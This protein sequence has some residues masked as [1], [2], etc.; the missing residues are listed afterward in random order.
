MYKR[1][2]VPLD[3]SRLAEGILPLVLLITGP[4]DLEV[5]LVRVVPPIP[6]QTLEGTGPFMVDVVATRL[7]EARE[8]LAGVAANLRKRGVRVITEARTG[9]PVTELV[10]AAREPGADLIAMTT[11]GRSG[12]GRLLF[13]SVA[14]AVLRQAKVP[15]LMMRLTER[16]ASTAEAA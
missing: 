12:F 1:V 8:Y 14:E 9:E 3:G 13:G 7:E 15:V 2:L 5:V 11:H 6:P 16:Q 4:L 10:A